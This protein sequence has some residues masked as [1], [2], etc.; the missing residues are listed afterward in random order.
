MRKKLFVAG[1]ISPVIYVLYVII[2]GMLWKGYSQIKQPISDLS[3]KGAPNLGMLNTFGSLSQIFGFI[4][5]ISAFI[6]LRRFKIKAVTISMVFFLAETLITFSYSF[7]PE[8]MPGTTLTFTGFMHLAV[9]A[10]VVITII[11]MLVF[12]GLGFRKLN[13]YKKFSS[14][15]IVTCIVIV[16]SG[17]SSGIVISNNIPVFGV[18][19]RI[20]I[21]ALQLWVFV[22]ALVLLNSLQ[23]F[24]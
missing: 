7:F 15:S 12:A 9:T 22:F 13:G 6:Y 3:A 16:I 23:E 24:E 19:E 20:N 11:L 14:Y 4:F 17:I 1:I 18:V 21:G 10:L 8:D 5:A 2:G